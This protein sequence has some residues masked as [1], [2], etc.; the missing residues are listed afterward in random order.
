[1]AAPPR[2]STCPVAAMAVADNRADTVVTV[3]TEA[4]TKGNKV[5]T[6]VAVDM[7]IWGKLNTGFV[8]ALS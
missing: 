8:I 6:G 5:D 1:M 7:V 3:V 2:C 4:V